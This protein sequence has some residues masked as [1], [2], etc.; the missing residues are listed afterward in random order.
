MTAL[1]YTQELLGD[2]QLFPLTEEEALHGLI[3][4]HR[5]IRE[6]N[7]ERVDRWLALPTWKKKLA[8][9]LKLT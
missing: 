6:M 2:Y 4:S 7:S 8:I 1:E 9:W 5:R 3:M